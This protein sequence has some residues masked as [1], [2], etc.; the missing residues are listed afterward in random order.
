[1][2]MTFIGP[3]LLL[4]AFVLCMDTT[5]SPSLAVGQNGRIRLAAGGNPA[6]CKA[7]FDRCWSACVGMASC[8]NQCSANY[9]GCLGQ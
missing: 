7:N 5:I 8:Q 1:M 4:C 9:R 2:R 6:V 3:A